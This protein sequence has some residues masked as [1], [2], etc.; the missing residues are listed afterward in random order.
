MRIQIDPNSNAGKFLTPFSCTIN[1]I[2]EPLTKSSG[3][4]TTVVGTAMT[5]AGGDLIGLEGPVQAKGMAREV[6]NLYR[7]LGSHSVAD[8]SQNNPMIGGLSNCAIGSG[9][10]GFGEN[11]GDFINGSGTKSPS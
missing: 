3:G 1:A 6:F 4:L 9:S 10:I 8:F 7:T 2:P 5:S 11:F